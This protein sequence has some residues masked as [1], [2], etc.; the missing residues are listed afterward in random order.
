VFFSVFARAPAVA[1]AA[2]A[3]FF[4][5]GATST[6]WVGSSQLLQLT[7]PNRILGRVLSIEL[8]LVTIV[9]AAVNAVLA[10]ALRSGVDP[11]DAALGLALAFSVPLAAWAWAYRRHVPALEE[12]ARRATGPDDGEP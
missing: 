6:V 2:I 1:V 10:T 8:A 7:V 5:H 4:A 11:R 3:L 12:A 9:I